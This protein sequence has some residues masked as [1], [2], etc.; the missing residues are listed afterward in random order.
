[1][2]KHFGHIKGVPEGALFANR[3]EL[4]AAGLHSPLQAGIS[5][6]PKEGADSIVMSG[7]YVD[8]RDLG[9]VI[10]Y[11]G[12]GGN[13]PSTKHQ[14]ADQ[15]L[16]RGN[17]GLATSC[18]QGLPVRVIRGANHGGP[19]APK[20][21]FRYD[22]L[23][24]VESYWPETGRDGY[25]IWR[26]RLERGGTTS[27]PEL[28]SPEGPTTP[29]PHEESDEP[30]K[31]ETATVQRIV[32]NTAHSQAVKQLHDHHCQVCG[33]HIETPIGA[34]S[35]GAHIR[36]L[37]KPHNGPDSPANL[38]CLCPNHHVML[39]RLAIYIDEDLV[40]RRTSDETELAKLRTAA[41][42]A[43]NPGHLSS[44]RELCERTKA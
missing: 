24:R 41:R 35:E 11:T 12:Q 29:T 44:Q 27:H 17:A 33:L 28:E 32:R 15:Q 1:M 21:G 25:R 10:I 18:D 7:G 13:D 34:Y 43:I 16:E 30:A 19:F 31:R 23:Y 26:F 9:D 37:G 20:A 39:D 38:L 5:G 42:H 22:G 4:A 3:K 14:V 6:N 8:D 40:V 2:A 36:P